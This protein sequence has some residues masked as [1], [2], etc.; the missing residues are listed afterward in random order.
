MAWHTPTGSRVRALRKRGFN[1]AY[2]NWSAEHCRQYVN[3][4]AFRRNEGNVEVD[5]QDRLDALFGRMSGKTIIYGEW[6]R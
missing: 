4:F 1:G 2:H 6:T 5:A 3:E